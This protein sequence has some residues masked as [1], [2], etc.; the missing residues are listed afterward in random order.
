MCAGNMGRL[1]AELFGGEVAHDFFAAAANSLYAY[2]SV[3]PFD[4]GA[5]QVSGPAKDLHGFA[6]AVLK[7]GRGFNL[8][9]RYLARGFFSGV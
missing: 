9:L 6:S 3:E 2:F 8:A 5:P 4:S 7:C 1:Q